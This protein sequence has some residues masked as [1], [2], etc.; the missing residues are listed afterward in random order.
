MKDD[1]R[2]SFKGGTTE[3][4]VEITR[5]GQRV[6]SRTVQEEQMNQDGVLE[7]RKVEEITQLDCGHIGH[8]A[9]ECPVCHRLFC[10][11]CVNQHG[12][13]FVCGGVACPNCSVS[14]VLDKN[15][16]YHK[17]CWPESV[18]RKIFG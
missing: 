3:R 5:I 11:A 7:K 8:A 15:R 9:G 16:R 13:C 6:M 18:K 17:V 10:Q 1:T 14:T 4:S 12:I 2:E